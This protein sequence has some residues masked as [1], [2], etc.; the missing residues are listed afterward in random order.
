MSKCETLTQILNTQKF[1]WYTPR[2]RE[3][4]K[5]LI[6]TITPFDTI[7]TSHI[8]NIFAWL[9]SDVE[10][11]RIKKP[12]IPPQH[13][14]AY[15]VPIDEE[16][17]TILVIEH[18]KA[19]LLLP[20]GGHIHYNEHPKKT[21][22]RE[23]IEELHIAADFINGNP[24]FATITQTVNIDAGHTDVSL[25]YLVK[26]DSSKKLHYN[27]NEF[28]KYHWFSPDEL[29]AMDKSKLDPHMHRF[30]KKLQKFYPQI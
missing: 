18:K 23:I 30:I 3:K 27:K 4:I 21:V 17:H 7:E 8:K 14:V 5:A 10:I 28:D 2:M 29:L 20:P 6:R 25:W 22:E 1:S 15:F 9:E 24:F 12:D 13:L 19:K 11:F 26:G 16:K